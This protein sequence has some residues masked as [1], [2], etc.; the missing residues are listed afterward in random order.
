MLSQRKRYHSKNTTL[1]SNP[2]ESVRPPVAMPKGV[3][4]E[5]K[6]KVELN[7]LAAG[8]VTG[9]GKLNKA[10]LIKK[11]QEIDDRSR[12]SSKKKIK[13]SP[14]KTTRGRAK[15]KKGSRSPSP[16]K[17]SKSR[18]PSPSKKGRSRSSSPSKKSGKTC[19]DDEG[20]STC[21]H[22]EYCNLHKGTCGKLTSK[23]QPFG[24]KRLKES[25]D[26]FVFDAERM[27]AGS[28]G[29]VAK[30]QKKGTS[31]KST[32]KKTTKK[33][34]PEIVMD[35]P[36]PPAYV[37]PP[38]K[39][40]SRKKKS[41]TKKASPKKSP[42][43]KSKR[44]TPTTMADLFAGADLDEDDEE[45]ED[46]TPEK[47]KKRS[48]KKS[49]PKKVKKTKK[50]RKVRETR[51]SPDEFA[52][53]PRPEGYLSP[54]K[55]KKSRAEVMEEIFGPPSPPKK[56]KRTK[57]T[58]P[59]KSP[60]KAAKSKRTPKK[61]EPL[62]FEEDAEPCADDK[63]CSGS[64]G[65]CVADTTKNR[66]GKWILN[67]DGKRILGNKEDLERLQEAQG[68]DMEQAEFA[69]EEK[70]RKKTTRVKKSSPK[71]S[72]EKKSS[73]KKSPRRSPEKDVTSS[74]EETFN[75]CLM[76]LSKSK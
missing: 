60:P 52:E 16:S 63:L 69:K 41:P 10:D 19:V 17:K 67:V 51:E 28:K 43:K 20:M 29:E 54:P 64:T 71:K 6:T 46:F 37:S 39:R 33:E 75:R 34:S 14:K 21:S 65:R 7:K 23:K 30:Q 22:N 42:P 74:I 59:K 44:K 9:Y 66:K 35:L 68:G 62:C 4:Y 3:D 50:T 31:K 2:L 76:E 56:T 48:P 36:S 53:L 15:S 70:P 18:S 55:R 26:E 72:P 25:I 61:K 8:K 24:I 57:K 49:P 12:G 45:D 5:S 1:F 58:S 38:K 11:L 27:I 40:T 32:K 13:I 73:P 47:K